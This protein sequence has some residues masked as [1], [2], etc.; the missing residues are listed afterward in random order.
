[1][2]EGD[3]CKEE[4]QNIKWLMEIGSYCGVC[5]CKGLFVCGQCILMNVWICKGLWCVIIVGKK[6]VKKQDFL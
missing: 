2:V 3:L 4:I 1:M 6:K 5:Y